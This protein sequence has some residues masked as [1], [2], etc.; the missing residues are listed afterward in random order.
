MSKASKFDQWAAGDAYESYMGRWSR[1]VARDFLDWLKPE[2]GADWIDVGCGTGAL[3]ETILEAAQPRSVLG[4]DPSPG[5]VGFA[6]DNAIDPRLRFVEGEA[7]RLPADNASYDAATSGLAVNFFP[8]PVAG[9]REMTRVV[10]PGGLLS[11]Y[12]WDYPGGGMGF[13]DA[14]W[15]AAAS[16]DASASALNERTRFPL[17]TPDGLASLCTDAGWSCD[18]APIQRETRFSDF[19]VFWEPFT[20]GAGPAPGYVAKLDEEDREK[21]KSRLRLDLGETNIVLPARAWAV[22]ARCAHA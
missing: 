13:I 4:V 3:S 15:K 8:D 17:C 19:E 16:I 18:V 21:L 7:G 12:V 20:R 2:A 10:R 11:F 6:N 5:F 14:F 1:Q 22:K 9:L